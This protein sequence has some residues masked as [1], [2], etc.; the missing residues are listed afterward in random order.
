M[1]IDAGRP[2]RFEDGEPAAAEAAMCKLFGLEA[3]GRVTDRAL[4]V[5]YTRASPIERL[6]RG[7]SW[8]EEGPPTVQHL[9]IA[10]ELLGSQA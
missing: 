5:G 8:L 7:L 9:T 1:A 3:V 10:R 2:V 6:P 4:L